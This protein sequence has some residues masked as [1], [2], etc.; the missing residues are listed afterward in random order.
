MTQLDF[1][2]AHSIL[3]ETPN[4][5]E[6]VGG[7]PQESLNDSMHQAGA[8]GSFP[9]TEK[10]SYDTSVFNSILSSSHEEVMFEAGVPPDLLET[11][12]QGSITRGFPQAEKDSYRA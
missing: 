6:Q 2:I 4:D 11:K 9:D 7:P 8:P 10:S 5:K 1:P 12:R 3:V